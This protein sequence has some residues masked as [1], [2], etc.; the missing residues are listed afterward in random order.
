MASFL[1]N[2]LFMILAILTGVAMSTQAAVNS[3]LAGNVQ[4]P[5]LAA[6]ISFAV[7]TVALFI[8]AFITGAPLGNLAAAKDAPPVAWIGGVLGAFFVLI[9]TMIVPRIGVALAFSLA[10]TGQ[11]LGAL[12][13]DHFGL[14]G[15]PEHKISWQRIVGVLFVM[16]GVIIIRRF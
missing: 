15:I 13:V 3:K 12:V 1:N 14:L 10:I 4:S 6:F 9:M 16:A 2:Y 7:G 5:V 8:W 11:M